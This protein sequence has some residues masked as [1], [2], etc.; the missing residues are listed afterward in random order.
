MKKKYFFVIISCFVISIS[1]K[2]QEPGSNSPYKVTADLAHNYIRRCIISTT[3]P[4][5]NFQHTFNFVKSEG[6]Y[7]SAYDFT[8]SK[9]SFFNNQI[10]KK[11]KLCLREFFNAASIK[12]IIDDSIIK[13][14]KD[15]IFGY[16]DKKNICYRFFNKVAYKI[17]NPSEKILLYSKTSLVGGPKNRSNNVTL[18]FFSENANSPIYRLS[19]WNLKTI[20]YKDVLFHEL[21]DVYF[22]SDKDLT[23]YDSYNKIYLLNRIYEISK[24]AISMINHN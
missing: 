3:T 23:A 19:K 12:I 1:A 21:L 17:I 5:P 11:Y 4:T 18:Y 13:L 14:N 7:L 16:R 20:L 9:I 8:N 24:Q 15:S 10:N 22:Q 2:A 6:V